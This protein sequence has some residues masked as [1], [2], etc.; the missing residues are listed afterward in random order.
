MNNAVPTIQ[1]FLTYIRSY[2]IAGLQNSLDLSMNEIFA[3]I[4][5]SLPLSENSEF[6][7]KVLAHV[8]PEEF[9]SP[10]PLGFFGAVTVIFLFSLL[11][12]ITLTETG[13]ELPLSV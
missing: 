5:A 6:A 10:L 1:P 13:Q 9:S 7:N 4:S 2:A 3:S 12:F 11:S 8:N